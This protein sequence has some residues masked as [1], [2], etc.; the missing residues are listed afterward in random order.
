MVP[1]LS[2]AEVNGADFHRL[3]HYVHPG[4]LQPSAAAE[5][6]LRHLMAGRIDVGTL[7]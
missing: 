2:G 3:N 6:V 5:L 4:S 7:N 1:P